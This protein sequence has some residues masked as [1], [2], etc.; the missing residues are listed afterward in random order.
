M[1]TERRPLPVDRSV[2]RRDLARFA[3]GAVLVLFAIIVIQGTSRIASSSDSPVAAGTVVLGIGLAIAVAFGI[4]SNSSVGVL[5]WLLAAVIKAPY[6]TSIPPIDR[7]A[8]L[9]LMGGWFISVVTHR[10]PLRAFGL[11][12]GVMLLYL[13]YCV[14]S[15]IAPHDLPADTT[16]TPSRLILD[17]GLYAFALFM[18]ARQTMANRRA[19]KTFL[20]CLVWYAIYL[21]VIA[22]FQKL[23]PQSLVWPRQIVDPSLGINPDR[24]RGPLLNSAADGVALVIGFCAAMYLA[25]QPL[26]RFRRFALVAALLMPIGIFWTNTR[27]IWLAAGVAVIVGAMFAAGFRRWYLVVLG[28][29]VAVIL[30]NWQKFLSADRTQ[31]GVTSESEIDAR[32]N[33]IATAIWGIQHKPIFGWGISRYPALNSEHHQAWGGIDWNLNNGFVSHNTHMANAAELGIIGLSLWAMVILSVIIVSIRTYRAV[34]RRGLLSK[35]LV[36]AFW[37]A[38]AAWLINATVIDMR[39]FPFINALTF[40]WAGIIAGM[41]DMAKEGTLELDP[42]PEAELGGGGAGPDD[43]LDVRGQRP[44]YPAFGD[45][46]GNAVRRRPA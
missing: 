5:V 33:D 18:L 46:G 17:T 2:Q 16:Y 9:A 10:R 1:T 30:I 32:L 25:S 15:A 43:E 19:V 11:T 38:G 23:G 28:S 42:E 34:P 8:F 20:W 31:G 6:A 22:V 41:G 14:G 36:L 35:G 40:V 27:A 21:T 44:Q 37:G 12:E 3:G 7:Y 45:L 24:A 26:L 13:L 29:A 39:L 4:A